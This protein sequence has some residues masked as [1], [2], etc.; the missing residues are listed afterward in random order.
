MGLGIGSGRGGR[1][2]GAGRPKGVKTRWPTEI[3]AELRRLADGSSAYTS[4]VGMS[5]RLWSLFC[6]ASWRSS[7]PS[8]CA[9][10]SRCRERPG[11]DRSERDPGQLLIAHFNSGGLEAAGATIAIACQH[12]GFVIGIRRCKISCAGAMPYRN[13]FSLGYDSGSAS[14]A[15]SL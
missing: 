15:N 13:P 1:R 8:G 9:R 14:T 3:A 12:Y 6:V 11:D 4:T 2:A 5:A 7:G 10:R